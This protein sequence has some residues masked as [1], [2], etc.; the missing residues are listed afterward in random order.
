MDS[1]QIRKYTAYQIV[2]STIKK[3]TVKQSKG[4]EGKPSYLRVIK[5]DPSTTVLSEQRPQ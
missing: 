3:R 5:K 2:I 1:K 4:T